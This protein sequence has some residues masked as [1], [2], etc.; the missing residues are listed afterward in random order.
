LAAWD[1]AVLQG[2]RQLLEVEARLRAVHAA[3][4]AAERQLGAVETHQREVHE[5]LASVEAEAERAFASSDARA[6]AAADADAAERD[7]LYGR[8]Q[9]VSA[10]LASL[11]AEL[12]EAVEGVNAAAAQALGPAD[13]PVG[14][15]VRILNAQLAALGQLEGRVAELSAGVDR[16]RLLQQAQQQ[17]QQ[18]QQ[19]HQVLMLQQQQQAQQQQRVGGGGGVRRGGGY[20]G[21]GGGY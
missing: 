3:Q 12:S 16:A 4:E 21:G 20:G 7:A 2:R 5:A 15:V 10:R 8:A 19:Q 6:F 9:R 18:Q 1:A 11:G 14:A 13:T 17:Q